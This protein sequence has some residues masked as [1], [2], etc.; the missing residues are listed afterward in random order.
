MGH[1]AS[2]VLQAAQANIALVTFDVKN[3]EHVKAFVMLHY[4]GRQHPTLRFLVEKP[5]LDVRSMMMDKMV[6]KAAGK[7]I[8]EVGTMEPAGE[9]VGTIFA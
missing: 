4:A 9:V 8:D 6:R 5:F 2:T 7:V 3:K 1:K